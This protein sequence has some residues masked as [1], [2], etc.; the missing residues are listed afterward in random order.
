V[1]EP[2]IG[3]ALISA[4]NLLSKSNCSAAVFLQLGRR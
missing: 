3:P 2:S 1:L 4:G